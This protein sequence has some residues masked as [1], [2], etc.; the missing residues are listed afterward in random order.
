MPV[1]PHSIP[2]AAT[3]YAVISWDQSLPLYVKPPVC[4][5]NYPCKVKDPNISE[6]LKDVWMLSQLFNTWIVSTS[7]VLQPLP[8]PSLLFFRYERRTQ[9]CVAHV[10]L[11][12]VQI[13]L[14][15]LLLYREAKKE[16]QNDSLKTWP[17]PC[18][19]GKGCAAEGAALLT[20]PSSLGGDGVLSP[21][22]CDSCCISSWGS[23]QT[24]LCFARH[25]S[26]RECE[27][28]RLSTCH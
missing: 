6:R 26:I 8:R 24:S 27:T 19:G 3:H 5:V 25:H 1:S 15:N 2:T 13:P 7:S 21:S 18:P 4:K 22:S 9:P 17:V 11:G 10:Q 20:S 12:K 28:T 16:S 14:W 23:I